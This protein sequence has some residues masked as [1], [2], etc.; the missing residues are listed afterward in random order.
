MSL[1]ESSNNGR[2]QIARDGS[3]HRQQIGRWPKKQLIRAEAP[4]SSTADAVKR[5]VR[6]A[7]SGFQDYWV[8]YNSLEAVPVGLPASPNATRSFDDHSVSSLSVHSN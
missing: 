1:A 3:H 2:S 8:T 4:G 7:A 6:C 5:G